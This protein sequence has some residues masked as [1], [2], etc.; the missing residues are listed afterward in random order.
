[1]VHLHIWPPPSEIRELSNPTVE[2]D[3]EE[4]DRQ[5][6]L[7]KSYL[8]AEDDGYIQFGAKDPLTGNWL[9]LRIGNE[10]IKKLAKELEHG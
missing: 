1:M 7:N 4:K 5:P 3:F 8:G 2:I 6:N 9:E 10:L